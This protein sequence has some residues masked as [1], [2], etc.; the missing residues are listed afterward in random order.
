MKANTVKISQ[1][2]ILPER[3]LKL[4]FF[5]FFFKVVK[6]KQQK[7]AAYLQTLSD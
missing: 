3:I 5:C 6:K 4:S 7:T 1:Q 2:W